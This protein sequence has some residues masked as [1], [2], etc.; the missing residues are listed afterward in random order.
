MESFSWT[1]LGFF[2][3]VMTLLIPLTSL[4]T[5][6]LSLFQLL[7][8]LSLSWFC[9]PEP[10]PLKQSEPFVCLLYHLNAHNHFH[11]NQGQ[12]QE[13][14]YLVHCFNSR[15]WGHWLGP[16]GPLGPQHLFVG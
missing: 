2:S 4:T 5:Q 14:L 7:N 13:G 15:A 8:P 16:N 9:L 1:S 6:K 11:E 10:L 12:I 3:N